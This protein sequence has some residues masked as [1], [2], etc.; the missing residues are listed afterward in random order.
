[1]ARK[2]TKSDY[3]SEEQMEREKLL[4]CFLEDCATKAVEHGICPLRFSVAKQEV[5]SIIK[6]RDELLLLA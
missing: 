5:E 1:M 4:L 6:E 2:K 3:I